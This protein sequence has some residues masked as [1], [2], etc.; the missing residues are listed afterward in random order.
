MTK[1]ENLIPSLE[2]LDLLTTDVEQDLLKKL[3]EFP[4]VVLISAENY[5]PHKIANYLEELAATFHKFY[6]ECRII[7]SEKNLAEARI[8]LAIATQIVLRNGLSILGVSA[9][10]KM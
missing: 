1:D 3:F 9:P 6:T 10:N 7:G 8:S 2:N 4:E 5:E